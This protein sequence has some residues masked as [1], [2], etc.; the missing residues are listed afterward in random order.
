MQMQ[1]TA[2]AAR[3]RIEEWLLAS[4]PSLDPFRGRET[5]ELA[6]RRKA[7]NEVAFYLLWR[8]HHACGDTAASGAIAHRLKAF[9]TDEFL[10]VAC[11]SPKRV[12]QFS[13]VL[14]YALRAGLPDSTRTRRIAALLTGRFAWNTEWPAFRQLDLLAACSFACLKA[15]LPASD[16]LAVCSFRLPPCPIHSDRDAFYALAH[17]ASY[18]ALLGFADRFS[19]EAFEAVDAGL[20]RT[21][22]ADD[23]DLG[24]ELLIAALLAQRGTTPAMHMH[25]LRVLQALTE[26]SL[27]LR[28]P[29]VETIAVEDFLAVCPAERTWAESAHL[30]LVAGLLLSLP[31]FHRVQWRLPATPQ[32]EF[33]RRVGTAFAHLHRYQLASGV[34]SAYGLRPADDLQ[35]AHL[36]R[37]REFI[38][39]SR[40]ADGRFG[41]YAEERR[42]FEAAHPQ[43]VFEERVREPVNAACLRF[44]H[45]RLPCRAGTSVGSNVY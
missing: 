14:A 17:S 45:D 9:V 43:A 4:M 22:A 41:L 40:N 3:A 15:P 29:S 11:R 1:N 19:E 27:P 32:R 37:I 20:C 13:A 35:R 28:A 39:L 23:P 30:M 18:A 8:S 7:L 38:E 31:A 10:D 44:L 42:L 2:A 6:F 16:A 34:S 25:A 36:E 33:V 24:M 12:L 5:A 21:W 26:T